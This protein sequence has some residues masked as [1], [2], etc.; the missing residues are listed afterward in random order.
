MASANVKNPPH[1]ENCASFELWE[2][3]VELWQSITDLKKEQQGPALVLALT[4]KAQEEVLELPT[5]EI[6]AASLK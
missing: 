2:K 3:K 5:A 6:K 1:L 4:A